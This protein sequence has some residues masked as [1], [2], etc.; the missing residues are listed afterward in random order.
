M[1]VTDADEG[2]YGFHNVYANHAALEVLRSDRTPVVYPDGATFVVSIFE[3]KQEKGLVV[4]GPK[5]RD[6][7]QVKDAKA[8]E[9]GGWRYGSFDP[10]GKPLRA[11]AAG[12]AA[13]HAQAATTD[14]VFTKYV[15]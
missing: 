3:V 10:A 15:R 7:V 4:A 11:D 12:C 6:V 14:M 1:V 5:Q 9:T 13:C 2:M 8:K